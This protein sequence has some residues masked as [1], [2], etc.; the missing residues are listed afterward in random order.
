MATLG[1]VPDPEK[2]KAAPLDPNRDYGHRFADVVHFLEATGW[3]KRLKGSHR[4]FTRA[5]IPA[6]LN[7]QPE[8]DGKAKA[9]QVR[10][11]RR[12]LFQF[13]P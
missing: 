8:D 12:A 13:D 11:V 4:I 2:T 9:Y 7:L 6:L 1:C 5:G 3:T 10:Q